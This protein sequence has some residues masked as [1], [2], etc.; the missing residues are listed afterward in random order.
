MA[1]SASAVT[2]TSRPTPARSSPSP[3]RSLPQR[4]GD[5]ARVVRRV[6]LRSKRL[7]R[8]QLDGPVDFAQARRRYAQR[9]DVTEAHRDVPGLDGDAVGRE[10]P[11][12]SG[13]FLDLV[14]L[15]QVPGLV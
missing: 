11:P 8:R 15:V 2:P 4:P 1:A 14:D 5:F 10:L 13:L 6:D 12:E 3:D 7:P 9:H